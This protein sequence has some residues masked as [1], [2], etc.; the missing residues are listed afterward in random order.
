[1]NKTN[2]GFTL[3]ELIVVL[4]VLAIIAA[5]L[6]PNF[7]AATD[8][9]RIRSDIQ[10]ARVIH[11]ALVLYRTERGQDAQ[12][13]NMTEILTSLQTAGY[14]DSGD[15]NK[16][17]QN[18]EWRQYEP[19]GIVVNISGVSDAGVHRAANGLPPEERQFVHG[20]NTTLAGG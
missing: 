10:S 13:S 6:I 4:A 14:L 17:T 9:A 2:N 12:G 18:A 11:N 16:Q 19:L 8:R 5:I 7:F 1:M 15:I 3:L 20:I